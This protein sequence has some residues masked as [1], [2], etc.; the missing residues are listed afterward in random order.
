MGL[1]LRHS[2]A[3]YRQACSP[4]FEEGQGPF[5]SSVDSDVKKEIDIRDGFLRKAHRT[6]Q[7]NDWSYKTATQQC[8]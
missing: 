3:L 5:M 2:S 7:E 6:N 1:F 8:I 4:Y